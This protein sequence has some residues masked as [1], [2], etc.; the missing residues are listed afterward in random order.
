MS[1]VT[2][3]PKVYRDQGGN[4]QV[5]A[6]G[7]LLQFG[8]DVDTVGVLGGGGT[9]ASPL[10]TSEAGKN[11]VDLRT[12]TTDASGGDSRGLYWRH[13]LSGAGGSGETIRAF[14]TVGAAGAVSAHGVHASVSFGASGTLAGE[15]AAVRGTF[16]VPNKQLGGTI[17][18]VY[19]ELWADGADS[20][21]SG[22]ASFLRCV[23]AGTAAGVT[24]L[25]G[26]AAL[27]SLEGV[28]VGAAGDGKVVDAISEDK[29]VT[30]LAKILINNVPYYVMLRNAV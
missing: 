18:A 30:H 20:D 19:S 26:K 16:Q 29:A 28:T 13:Y 24:T 15:A 12:K 21:V 3:H 14:T 9:N 22:P 23:L 17:A 5:V 25:N 6:A 1:D 4:R 27:L 2:Y 10:S 8:D 7:G 11:F